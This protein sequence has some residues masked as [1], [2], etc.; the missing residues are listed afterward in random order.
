MV[1][2]GDSFA[3]GLAQDERRPLFLSTNEV[4]YT[5]QSKLLK[6]TMESQHPSPLT[7]HH[8]EETA[9]LPGV[10]S[11]TVLGAVSLVRLLQD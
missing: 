3:A 11:W 9:A 1:R 6:S 8:R 10:H 5:V 7:V 4:F 2:P